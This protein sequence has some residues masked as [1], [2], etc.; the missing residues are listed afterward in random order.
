L[1]YH[2]YLHTHTAMKRCSCN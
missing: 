1:I 2:N